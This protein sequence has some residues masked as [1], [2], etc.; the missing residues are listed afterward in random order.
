M[1]PT[2]VKPWNAALRWGLRLS[3]RGFF[4]RL[5]RKYADH[6]VA[7]SAAVLGYYFVFSLFPFLFFLAALTA[8]IPQARASVDTLLERARDF[9]PSAAMGLIE[10]HLRGLVT[11]S[12]P[13]LLTLGLA[14]ALY[15]AS[16]GVNAVRTALNRA[17]DVKETRPLW[18]TELIAFGVTVGGG[19]LMLVGIAVLLGGGGVGLWV[20]R[21]L[22]IGDEYVRV[23]RLIRWPVTTVVI[24][25][26][27]ALGYYLLPNV[28]QRFK[29][30][31]PGSV[32]GTLFW[33]L[34]SWGFGKY[35]SNFGSYNVTYGSIGGVIVLLTWFYITGFILLMGGELNAI[36]EQATPDGKKPGARK[37]D[38]APPPPDE[39]PSAVP[40]GATKSA[41]VAKRSRGGRAVDRSEG[42]GTSS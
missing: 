27:A 10:P 12:R 16:R 4:Q 24:T 42:N 3:W 15:S 40:P 26:G 32:I 20:A 14:A 19:I 37:F 7:D 5:Y 8:F 35:V 11:S 23:L 25:L 6:A 9:L 1:I 28:E 17:Y 13:R 38:Q 18:K 21:H 34:A 41:S 36:I 2:E 33:F 39:R 31:T 29:F 22:E 30:I